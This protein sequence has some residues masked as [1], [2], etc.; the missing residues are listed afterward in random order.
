MH[1]G[2]GYSHRKMWLFCKSANNRSELCS[3]WT[4]LCDIKDQITKVWKTTGLLLLKCTYWCFL[5]LRTLGLKGTERY[6][7]DCTSYNT[8]MSVLRWMHITG[9]WPR[10]ASPG[11]LTQ[12]KK[13]LFIIILCHNFSGSLLAFPV[14]TLFD[15]IPP[16]Y[17]AQRWSA[18]K[19]KQD[20]RL[21]CSILCQP[22]FR[23][24]I[25]K[26]NTTSTL[27]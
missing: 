24:I 17:K 19:L 10:L 4:F 12:T 26:F 1:T 14:C 27:L 2:D 5:H 6:S 20:F 23:T 3:C 25:T 7:R 11:C 13:R 15:L 9:F 21:T 8:L 22:N 16:W 18:R